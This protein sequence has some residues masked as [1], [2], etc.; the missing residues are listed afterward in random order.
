M[1][2]VLVSVPVQGGKSAKPHNSYTFPDWG[3]IVVDFSLNVSD[4][5]N[6]V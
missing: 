3:S 5:M 4:S 2:I 6:L 1:R